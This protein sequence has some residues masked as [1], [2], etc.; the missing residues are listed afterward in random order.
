MQVNDKFFYINIL[1]I[2]KYHNIKPTITNIN[3]SICDTLNPGNIYR[4]SVRK[5]SINK[6]PKP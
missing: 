6:R 4:L 2:L 3:D 5:P 1:R